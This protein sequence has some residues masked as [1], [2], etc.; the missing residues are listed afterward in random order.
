MAKK[1]HVLHTWIKFHL[2]S[3]GINWSPIYIFKY[4]VNLRQRFDVIWYLKINKNPLKSALT[5]PSACRKEENKESA[6]GIWKENQAQKY[7]KGRKSEADGVA[8]SINHGTGLRL[9]PYQS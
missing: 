2:S 4:R 3:A 5:L 8:T 9:N 1:W 7:V 6:E